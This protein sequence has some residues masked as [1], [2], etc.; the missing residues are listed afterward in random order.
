MGVEP[1]ETTAPVA[2]DFAVIFNKVVVASEKAKISMKVQVHRHRNPTPD[3]KVTR[4]T[5]NAVE[6]K[7]PKTLRIH[8]V[9]NVSRV[10]PYLGP[11]PGQPVSRTG[12]VQV[13]EER[14][15][16]YEV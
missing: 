11:L 14:D 5:P 9:V 6:L 15:E 1:A 3:Y 16:E 2:K 4:V 7:L 12:L 13:S 10:K 8:L